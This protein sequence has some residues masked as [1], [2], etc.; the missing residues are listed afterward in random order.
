MVDHQQFFKMETSPVT[1]NFHLNN[2]WSTIPKINDGRPYLILDC[3]KC[4]F[5][6]EKMQWQPNLDEKSLF[7]TERLKVF[8][9]SAFYL[10]PAKSANQLNINV[11][12]I[13]VVPIKILSACCHR[14]V[15]SWNSS[16]LQLDPWSFTQGFSFCSQRKAVFQPN[17]RSLSCGVPG[18]IVF[19]L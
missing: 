6:S 10:T 8:V 2:G 14:A 1:S 7:Q 16:Y 11:S 12:H 17:L 9:P 18:Q 4:R 3:C 5:L 13:L 15:F 19:L